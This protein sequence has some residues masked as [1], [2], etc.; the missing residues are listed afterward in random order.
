MNKLKDIFYD[1]SDILV[2]L[3]I[4]CVAA[5]VIIGRIDA[6]IAYPSTRTAEVNAPAGESSDL[7]DT[8]PQNDLPGDPINPSDDSM[9][10]PLSTDGENTDENQP[11][12]DSQGSSLSVTI[13]YGA[14]GEKIAD[15]LIKANL[16]DSRQQFYD[17]VSKAGADTKLQAGTFIIPANATPEEVVRI[18]TK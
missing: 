5:F 12:S 17:A 13:D 7:P 11:A 10:P 14:T 9:D 4:V 15:L 3:I 1:K 16:M 6:I 18:I 8:A 2:A